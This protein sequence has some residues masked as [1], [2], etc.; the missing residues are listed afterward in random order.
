MVPHVPAAV[1]QPRR[2]GERADDLALERAEVALAVGGAAGIDGPHLCVDEVSLEV[3]EVIRGRRTWFPLLL[4]CRAGVSF[5]KSDL[6]V[7]TME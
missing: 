5:R 2:V 1:K 6:G 3:R 7:K 4:L